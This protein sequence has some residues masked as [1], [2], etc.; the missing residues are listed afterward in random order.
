RRGEGREK[1]SSSRAR[2]TPQRTRKVRFG[3]R[4][5]ARARMTVMARIMIAPAALIC[6]KLISN[7][8]LQFPDDPLQRLDL[9]LGQ[10]LPAQQRREQL[11]G[12]AV[13]NS[14]DQLVG[15]RLLD[16]LLAD[17]RVAEKAGVGALYGPLLD[18]PLD[19]GVGGVYVPPHLLGQHLGDVAGGRVPL[20][21]EHAH[22]LQFRVEE[23]YVH[24]Q[25]L[26]DKTG[27]VAIAL[28]YHSRKWLSIRLESYYKEMEKSGG[29]GWGLRYH[30][31]HELHQQHIAHRAAGDGQEH[32]P[33]P[34]VQ[35]HGEGDGD[36]LRQAVAPGRQVHVPQAVDHQHAKDRRRQGPAQVLDVPGG[37]AL[38]GEDQEGQEPGGHGA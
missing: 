29:P 19:E 37:G 9:L 11:V 33:L 38:F 13:V 3:S 16:G 35:R 18:A 6:N 5:R 27:V 22:D 36:A 26:L 25:I 15:L 28:Y 24:G 34:Q 32:L 31:E 7:T 10:V 1:G 8:S 2:A 23:L 12:G 30:L 17:Q 21:P 14:V 4:S 20:P